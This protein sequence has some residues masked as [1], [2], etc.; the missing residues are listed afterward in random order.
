LK[1]KEGKNKETD[2]KEEHK[3]YVDRHSESYT[4]ILE[5]PSFTILKKS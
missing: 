2:Q 1:K 3:K 5:D 4:V